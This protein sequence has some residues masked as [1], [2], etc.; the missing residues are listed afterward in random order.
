MFD[1]VLIAG[2]GLMGGSMAQA[3]K[4]H[5]DCRVLGWNRTRET[6]EKAKAD[7][8]IDAVAGEAL[9]ADADLVIIG[10]YPQATVDWLLEHMPKFKKGCVIVDMVG[11]KQ[12]MADR[13]EKPALELGLHFVGGHPMAGREF[14]GLDYALPTLFDGAS[15]ILVP[16]R[17][18]TEPVLQAL[19]AFFMRLG[20][21]QTVRCT[22]DQHDRMIAFT[23]QLAHVVSSAY[24]KSPEADQ[25]NGYSA[26]S[27]RDLTRVAKLNETMWSELFLCNAEP[28]AREIDEVIGHLDEYRRAIR[29]GD[30]ET[31][32][33]LLRDGRER[34]ERLG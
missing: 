15:M 31:L 2:L 6:A 34:K 27:Y 8:T 29:A 5:T 1:T 32:T 19:E 22:A 13:L 12:F 14:S 20:F 30:R 24:I 33:A 9:F 4:R 10:L 21:G 25:H 3:I 16:N 26:G 11:V 17:S 7:G 18:S 23:S 28:L